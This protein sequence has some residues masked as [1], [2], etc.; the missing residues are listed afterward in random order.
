MAVHQTRGRGQ[1]HATWQSDPG[2]NLTISALL[3]PVSLSIQEQFRLV[4]G[5]SLAL[6]RSVQRFLPGKV[7]R[8]KWPNDLYVAERK[9]GGM[10]VENVLQGNIWK[11]AIV[12]IGLNVN[13]FAFGEELV[14]RATS[15]MLESGQEL[16]LN[17]VFQILCQQLNEYYE[18]L[19][20]DRTENYDALKEEYLAA[21]FGYEQE[22]IF[23]LEGVPVSGK[24]IDVTES[25]RLVVD[26]Y[27][28]IVDF[29]IKEIDFWP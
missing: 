19:H 16:D 29:G 9:I 5:F 13:Q 23:Y 3:S 28:Q 2:K 22:R 10:L 21:L 25:G 12:G 24:I 1:I 26:F 14:D 27:P 15:I 4:M 7:V 20:A 11:H 6:K 17:S 18:R 8:I